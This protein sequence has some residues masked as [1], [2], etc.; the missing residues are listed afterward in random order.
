[1]ADSNNKFF[2]IGVFGNVQ[3]LEAMGGTYL[4]QANEQA[5]IEEA[6]AKII[7]EIALDLG[8]KDVTIHDGITAMTSTTLVNGSVDHFRYEI[9]QKDGTTKVYANGTALR[10]DYPYI[11]LAK[12]EE[13]TSSKAVNWELG[14]NY[15]LADGVTYKVIF[16]VWPSQEAY[17]LLADLNNGTKDYD[18]LPDNVKS[19]I[20]VVEEKYYL[21]TNTYSKIDYTSYKTKDGQIVETNPVKDAEIKDP[22]GKMILDGTGL[23]MKKEWNDDLDPTQLLELLTDHLNSDKTDTTYNVVL[24]LW[25]DKD[26][27]SE[28]E[29]AT[30]TYPSPNGFI[31]KPEV[32]ITDG[33][34]TAA[35]WPT[36][37]VAI[38][39]GVLV[40]IT[41]ENDG[42][43]DPA[44]YQRFT[45]QGD[46]YAMLETGHNYII[47]EDDTDLH[48][49]L[50]TDVYH[51]MVVDGTL[52]NVKFGSDGS[53]ITEISTGDTGLSTLTA[54]NDLKGGLDIQKFVTSKDDMSDNV[55]SDTTYFTYKIKLQKSEDDPTPVYTT[56]DQFNP[57]GSTISGSLGFRIF[58][59]PVIPDNATDV[60]E[61]KSTFVFDGLT[62]KANRNSSGEIYSYTARGTI[63]SSGELTLRIRQ[64]KLG[65]TEG[66]LLDRIRIVNIPAGTYYTVEEIQVPDGYTLIYSDKAS[67]YVQAN[68]QPTAEFWNKRTSSTVDLLKVDEIDQS[69]VLAEAEFSLFESN[70]TTPAKDA[71][72]NSIGT[73]KTDSDGKATIG[74]L[75]IGEYK[76]VETVAPKGYNLMSSPITI[77]V[78]ADKVT[79]RLGVGQPTDAVKSADGLTWTITATNNP[80]VELPATGGEGTLI[81]SVL[82]TILIL[83]STLLILAKR[84]QEAYNLRH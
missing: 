56:P 84:K 63:P 25:Q 64:S 67:G 65:G 16:T 82:G 76:L 37:G 51:P 24:R 48:F 44:R 43:Y 28:K 15:Q 33:E 53:T 60:A 46:T 71:D 10:E 1:M 35:K 42:L 69:K 14:E 34:V 50:N 75:G 39:P 30:R 23:Q 54:A 38:A 7:D 72:G 26:T 77:I 9:T 45:Y 8:Y 29:I 18:A 19:Q 80:G 20:V 47:T 57:D 58:A 41:N 73:I 22:K 6:F 79:Y 17:D 59:A 81:F 78:A 36:I 21:K 3:Y 68:T 12:Y 32:T 2:S 62:Y 27:T 11:G 4:G 61:D 55:A 40:T 31:Y 49:E 66:N 52:R 13:T 74:K 83:S 70:G 5:K